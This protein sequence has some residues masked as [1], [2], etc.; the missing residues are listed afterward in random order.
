MYKRFNLPRAAYVPIA[1]L[2][3]YLVWGANYAV[4]KLAVANAPPIM[5]AGM[6]CA[7]AGPL[8]L[9]LAR[10]LGNRVAIP[11][12]EALVV[13]LSAILILVFASAAVTWAQQWVA[14]NVAA[15]IIASSALWLTCFGCLGAHGER[16]GLLHLLSLPLGLSGLAIILFFQANIAAAPI[17]CLLALLAAAMSLAAGSL[18]LRRQRLHSHPLVVA[19]WQA[20]IAGLILLSLALLQQEHLRWSWT[21]ELSWA[22]LYLSV[23][24]SGFAYAVYCWLAANVSPAVLGSISYV[25]PAIAVVLGSSL[26]GEQLSG[27]QWL[28][29]LCVLG[30][31]AVLALGS[32]GHHF[33]FT[34]KRRH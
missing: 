27:G 16:P 32:G 26:L 6:R 9:L 3:V 25:H 18:L 24:G 7:I 12:R 21:T 31:I 4:I 28:G 5:L 33:R 19:G 1:L 10:L 13:V 11:G 30:S 2:F 22:L 8:L 34:A 29:V 15:L 17:P 14:S 23:M 20:C